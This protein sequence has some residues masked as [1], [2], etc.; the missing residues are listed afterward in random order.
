MKQKQ[1]NDSRLFWY[2][3]LAKLQTWIGLAMMFI[4]VLTVIVGGQHGWWIG[5]GIFLAI[6]ING[7]RMRFKFKRKAG[8]ILFKG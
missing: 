5:F 2:N 7:R 4:S 8:H 6:F 3:I 1:M